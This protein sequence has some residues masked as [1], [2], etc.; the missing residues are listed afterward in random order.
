MDTQMI[1]PTHI[2]A[3][4]SAAGGKGGSRSRL[5]AALHMIQAPKLEPRIMPP[6]RWP[7]VVIDLHAAA[8]APDTRIATVLEKH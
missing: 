4:R 5:G 2:K 3:H 7:Q 6:Q 1:D 8:K